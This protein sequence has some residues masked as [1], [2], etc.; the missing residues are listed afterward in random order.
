VTVLLNW[1]W[2][3]IWTLSSAA[4][5]VPSAPPPCASTRNLFSVGRVDAEAREE[6]GLAG[7]VLVAVIVEAARLVK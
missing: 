3:V 6:A 5:C 7:A 4:V 2:A 1:S